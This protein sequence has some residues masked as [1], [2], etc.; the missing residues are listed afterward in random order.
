MKPDNSSSAAALA[1]EATVTPAADSAAAAASTATPTV[2]SLAEQADS[3][4]A[5]FSIFS[6]IERLS[7]DREITEDELW[8]LPL[9][10]L[11]AHTVEK[12]FIELLKENPLFAFSGHALFPERKFPFLKHALF[13]NPFAFRLIMESALEAKPDFEAHPDFKEMLANVA[14]YGINAV[15]N[16]PI[17]GRTMVYL[18]Q[19]LGAD[20]K[21]L[22]TRSTHEGTLFC[23]AASYL[24]AN[25]LE[26]MIR[27]G[28]N[29]NT[30]SETG[31]FPISETLQCNTAEALEVMA[32]NG[33]HVDV[34]SGNV[35][36][37][38]L[39]RVRGDERRS[40]I[41]TRYGA[42][43]DP[44]SVL[45]PDRH[46]DY[47]GTDRQFYDELKIARYIIASGRGISKITSG[48][49]IPNTS[50]RKFIDECENPYYVLQET[51][52]EEKM[53]SAKYIASYA[54]VPMAMEIEKKSGTTVFNDKIS[55]VSHLIADGDSSTRYAVG[56]IICYGTIISALTGSKERLRVIIEEQ[57]ARLPTAELREAV[58]N[59]DFTG[60][61]SLKDYKFK[62]RS[63]GLSG[64]ETWL[65]KNRAPSHHPSAT[66][67]ATL[68][69]A[70]GA[71]ITAAGR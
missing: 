11:K 23:Q 20:G 60:C 64:L 42:P 62:L 68:E 26:E 61:P 67:G 24:P 41:L 28:F 5:P 45:P 57:V 8:S 37:L 31:I 13:S 1:P 15:S 63:G 2:M 56:Q 10:E 29:P 30:L 47:S 69:S 38:M 59:L 44:H 40:E 9:S 4:L 27:L 3:Q 51:P 32:R 6:T 12:D 71:A 19:K 43:L 22:L 54:A 58:T 52:A 17:D 18:F 50:V 21:A 14:L 39:T 35:S 48:Y 46:S 16:D 34:V 49:S 55:S 36:L 66:S 25:A 53:N 70:A 7:F 33:A 65:T